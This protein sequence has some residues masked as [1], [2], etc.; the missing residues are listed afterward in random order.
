M[1]YININIADP[2]M[3]AILIKSGIPVILVTNPSK[4]PA[5]INTG[6]SPIT[7]FNPFL[8]PFLKDC[9]RE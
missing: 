4:K 5:M 7:I 2:K 6:I 1:K 9:N 8:A 3:I